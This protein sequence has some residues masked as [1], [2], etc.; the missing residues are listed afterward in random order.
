ME[1]ECP[2]RIKQTE[3]PCNAIYGQAYNLISARLGN[4]NKSLAHIF[5]LWWLLFRFSHA[6][7]P[8]ASAS[9]PA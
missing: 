9:E 6:A 5:H 3:I 7:G 4:K 1:S 8:L 2:C